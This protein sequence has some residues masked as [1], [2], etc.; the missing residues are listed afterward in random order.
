MRFTQTTLTSIF[1]MLIISACASRGPLQPGWVNGPAVDYPAKKYLLG[2]GQDAHQDVARD[3]AR[4]DLAK[5]FEVAI[6]ETS[7]DQITYTSKSD[8][9]SKVV[10]MDS[11]TGR[12]IDT[13]TKQI[14]S[15][16]VISEIWQEPKSGQFHILATLDR[17]KAANSL[18]NQ[19]NKIDQATKQAIQYSRGS[20][21]ILKQIGFA[22]QALQL[23][24]ERAA[25]QKHLKVVSHTGMG[26][27]SAYNIPVLANDLNDLL[28][29]VKISVQIESDP[30]GGLN[31][32]IAGALSNSAFSHTTNIPATYALNCKLLLD[33]H[34]DNQGWF[35]QRGTLEI[36]LRDPDTKKSYGSQHW[37]IKVSS[38][39]EALAKKRVRDKINSILNNEIRQT[40][41]QFASTNK[42]KLRLKLFSQS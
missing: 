14:I 15:G 41:I 2:K 1:I 26:L 19:I 40:L 27:S 32:I 29:R 18:R 10:Q 16:I 33:T 7:R 25:Y 23:Q 8:G 31:D 9:K 30:I 21:E 39:N 28:Q 34:Q 11:E 13:Q 6:T 4:A 20:K 35:W 5:V 36:N 22:N 42:N 38:Q 12:D 3:R 17:F 24:L 37:S